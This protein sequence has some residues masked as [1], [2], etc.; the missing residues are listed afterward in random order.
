ME[1][2]RKRPRPYKYCK[3]YL[4]FTS[5]YYVLFMVFQNQPTKKKHGF[6]KIFKEK[7]E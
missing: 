3:D 4:K 6:L 5:I 7:G 1:Q 2:S